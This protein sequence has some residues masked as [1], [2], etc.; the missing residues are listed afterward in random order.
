ME[1]IKEKIAEAIKTYYSGNPVMDDEEYEELVAS[2]G[3]SSFDIEK[4]KKKSILVVDKIKHKHP[5]GTLPKVHSMDEVKTSGNTIY[6]AKYD[7][8]SIEI[9]HDSDGKMDYACTRGDYTYGENRTDIASE[10][11]DLGKVDIDYSIKNASVRGELLVSDDDWKLLEGEF[12]NQRNAASGIA[13]RDDLSYVKF[14]TFIP[15]DI[16]FDDSGD[17]KL[18]TGSDGAPYWKSFEEAEKSLQDIGVPTDGIVIKEYKD[19]KQVDA[20]A[21]KFTDKTYKTRIRDVRWQ[22]GRTGKL[23]PVAEFDTVF[24]DAEVSKASLG[25]YAIFKSLD[26]HY[27][28]EIEVKK[29]NMIIPQVVK[30]LGGGSKD[31]IIAPKWWN[32]KKTYVEGAHLFGYNDEHWR[33]TLYSQVNSLAGKG[34]SNAFVDKCIEQYGVTTFEDLVEVVNKQDFKVPGVGEAK[35]ANA[36]EALKQ[37]GECTM[38]QFLSSLSIDH[39]GWKSMEKIVAKCA[40]EAGA[41]NLD[42]DQYLLDIQSPYEFVFAISGLGDAA[43]KAFKDNFDFI[44][45]QLYEFDHAFGHMPKTDDFKVEADGPEVVVTG[46]FNDGLKRG[47]IE[48]LLRNNNFNVVGKVTSNTKY[49]VAGIGGGSKRSAAEALGVHIVE[50]EGDIN[51]GLNELKSYETGENDD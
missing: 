14:L 29:A 23:T 33:S 3:M 50:T 44:K 17:T 49:L 42:A 15:Y 41:L 47:D 32:G 21:Y 48:T 18:Y 51:A 39:L 27:N 12:K 37:A 4:L 9:H 46:K 31:E 19:D 11:I 26:L 8:C 22:L 16:V 34:V 20:K 36:R 10:L 13:N 24:I 5:M 30:N 1:T 7:G 28:D 25:S 43:A 6:Q 35:T 2:S 40:S 38:T 45:E